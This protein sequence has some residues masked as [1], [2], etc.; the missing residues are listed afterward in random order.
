M[1]PVSPLPESVVAL[2]PFRLAAQIVLL[3]TPC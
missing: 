1:I 3:T 2:L